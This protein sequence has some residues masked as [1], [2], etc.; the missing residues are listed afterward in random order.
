[1][2]ATAFDIYK[3]QAEVLVPVVRALE[4]QMGEAEAHRV[5]RDAL[6][7]HF[8]NFGKEAFGSTKE[9][10]GE[11]FGNRIG[12]LIDMFAADDA[13]DFDVE[14]Q[15]DDRFRFRVNRCK[16]AEF[17]K[18]LGAPELGFLFACY[19]DY[20]FNNGMGDDIVLERPQTIMEGATHCQ[21]NWY[22]ARDEMAA[23]TAREAE[24]KRAKEKADGLRSGS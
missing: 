7:D 22:V 11:H 10:H 15:S 19:Q 17:Y 12:A 4:K 2:T 5:I 3:A 23:K 20:P 16:Y 21:F 18:Q 9:T 13:L 6:G 8:R 14:E 24:E 1:M